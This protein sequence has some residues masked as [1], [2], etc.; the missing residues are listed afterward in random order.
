MMA[1]DDQKIGN[2]LQIPER[3]E[4]GCCHTRCCYAYIQLQNSE[5][6]EGRKSSM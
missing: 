4:F 3:Q 2:V 1:L 6:R 5:G